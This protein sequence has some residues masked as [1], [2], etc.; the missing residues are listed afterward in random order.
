MGE[1]S[2]G[3]A[4][5]KD[6]RRTRSLERLGASLA[7]VPG[8]TMTSV[9]SRAAD[10][11]SAYRLLDCEAVTHTAVTQ[12]HCVKVREWCREPGTFLMIEDTTTLSFP[13][14]EDCFGLGP[15]GEDHTRGFFAH[16]TMA[17][18]WSCSADDAYQDEARVV[19]F[20]HQHV[21]ARDPKVSH[22]KETRAQRYQRAGLES[23][24]WAKTFEESGGPGDSGAQWIFVGDRE[25]D[26]YE[27]FGR[28]RRAKVNF[29]ARAM[30][31]RALSDQALHVHE[32]MAGGKLMGTRTIELAAGPGRQARSATLEARACVLNLRGV[33]RAGGSLEDMTVHGVEVREIGAPAGQEPVYW[34]LLTDLPIDSEHDVWKIV[35][36]Y[37]RRWLI[38]E[39]HKALKTG[40]GMEKS[41]LTEVRKLMALAGI[42]SVVCMWLLDLK[43][44]ARAKVDVPLRPDQADAAT[45][46]ILESKTGRPKTGWSSRTLLVAIA[47]LGGYL[48][49]KHDGPPGWQTI[50]RGWQRLMLLSEGYHLARSMTKGKRCG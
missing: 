32:A 16:T 14:L 42:L 9:M 12:S 50:W 45:M 38:E 3:G 30:Q 39:Y 43:L 20:L 19:G 44:E 5:L 37:R 4:A 40:V 34:M 29:V 18:R 35:A 36:I 2:F 24:R 11:K 6:A 48:A 21:W 41:Q 27:V 1:C 31:D 25:S 26:I 23:D 49:R 17:V 33:Y 47:K 10:V 22:R 7:Q 46:E 15:V 28:C 8:G 13:G